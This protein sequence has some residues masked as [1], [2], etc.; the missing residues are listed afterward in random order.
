MLKELVKRIITLGNKIKYRKTCNISKLSFVSGKCFFEGENKIGKGSVFYDSFMGYASYMG[1][2][3]R[4]VNVKIGRYCSIGSNVKVI[5][6]THPVHNMISTHPAFYSTMYNRLSYV[7]KS[8]FQ[9]ELKTSDGFSCVIGNDVWIGDYV[10]I[11][12]GVIIGDGAII[13]M[14]A[15]VTKDVLPYEIVGGIPAKTIKYRFSDEVVKKLLIIKWWDKPKEWIQKNAE[16]FSD[17]DGFS[18]LDGNC[19]ESM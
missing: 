3:N 1:N 9:E 2:N 8:K 4:F 10:L 14:G 16:K 12:G 18:K 11:K 15:V 17:V 7:E 19:D 13:G 6:S 5:S